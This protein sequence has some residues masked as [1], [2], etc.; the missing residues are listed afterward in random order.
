[1]VKSPK[2]QHSKGSS[3]PVTIELPADDVKRV[4]SPADK[5][6]PPAATTAP[7]T[8]AKSPAGTAAAPSGPAK[9]Q[10]TTGPADTLAAR[11]ATPSMSANP[12]A[13][14]SGP[15]IGGDA[16]PKPADAAV[17]KAATPA[18]ATPTAAPTKPSDTP[19][20]G[21]SP[22][23]TT[24]TGPSDPAT[25]PGATNFGRDAGKA[26]PP[27][28][29]PP[30]AAAPRA[31]ANRAPDANRGRGGSTLAAGLLGGVIALAGAG[32]AW[33][34]GLLPRET[35]TAAQ[36]ADTAAVAELTTQL[37]AL[38]TEIA[39]LKANPPAAGAA[40][41][42]NA[43]MQARVEGLAVTVE[44]LRNR[45]GQIGD[46]APQ[47][48]AE[49]L[50]P[51]T[52]RLAALEQRVQAL[53]SD[54][55]ALQSLR[56]AVEAAAAQA[57]Q[58]QQAAGAAAPRLQEVATAVET[59]RKSVD[60]LAAQV[61]EQTKKPA[62]AQAI[63]ASALKSAIDSGRPFVAELDTYAGVAPEAPGV[64][65]LRALAAAGVPAQATLAGELDTAARAMVDAG[66]VVDPNAGL[67]DRL[68]SSAQSLV[69]VRPVGEAAGSDVP[70]IVARIEL[71][72]HN[73]DYARAVSE[74]GTLPDAPK[75]AGA[76]FME[77]VK[78]RA[79]AD[80]LAAAALAAA[81]RA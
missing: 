15:K 65:E 4:S 42:G 43:D 19:K 27:P 11:A 32:A 2:I 24:A 30:P 70:S 16:T 21:D 72:V 61:A 73:G 44:E 5:S 71:A 53:P 3:E 14:A 20:P 78:A 29:P 76:A 45:L 66:R 60:G 69:S 12:A 28:P 64:S 58:A 51:L 10:P 57:A 75:K 31:E 34:G 62:V 55:A 68:L 56:Q 23:S 47:S 38:R 46:A 49:S 17:T 67:V 54:D 9:P 79:R 81:L 8:P 22:K 36:P 74:Y 33:Y 80:E 52:E 40:S 26:P 48:P 39:A 41:A 63:A 37:G 13:S 7:A 35:L 1:M 59:L 25:K 6:A 77:K 50:A 18:P